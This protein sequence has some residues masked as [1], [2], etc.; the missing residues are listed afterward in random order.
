MGGSQNKT[1]KK[2]TNKKDRKVEKPLVGRKGVDGD[3]REKRED[4]GGEQRARCPNPALSR[5]RQR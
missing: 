4:R 3:E 5:P 1:N 2:Q